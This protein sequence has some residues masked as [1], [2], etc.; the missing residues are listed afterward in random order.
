MEIDINMKKKENMH[1]NLVSHPKEFLQELFGTVDVDA[2]DATITSQHSVYSGRD[3][4]PV[5]LR[6]DVKGGLVFNQVLLHLL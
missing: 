4:L 6:L 2:G 5:L 1:I 3:V